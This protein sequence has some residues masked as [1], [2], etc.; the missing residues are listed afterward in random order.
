MPLVAHS[1]SLLPG[2]QIRNVLDDASVQF[3]CITETGGFDDCWDQLSAL[4]TSFAVTPGRTVNI[5]DL[6]LECL[7]QLALLRKNAVDIL[8]ATQVVLWHCN[9]PSSAW[10]LVLSHFPPPPTASSHTSTYQ[11]RTHHTHTHAC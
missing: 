5:R 2:F 10:C 11:P 4:L 6:A 3:G 8:R 9:N 1:L 7:M